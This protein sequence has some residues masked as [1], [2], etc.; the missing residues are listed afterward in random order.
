MRHERTRGQD[1][2]LTPPG[3]IEALGPFDLDPCAPVVRPW[4]TAQAHYTIEDDGLS[5]PWTG[6]VWMNPPYG[7]ATP[8]WIARLAEHGQ[9][10]ALLMVRTD[11][12]WFQDHVFERA[13]GLFFL[14]GR[15]A[16]HEPDGRKADPA[17]APCVLVG[18]GPGD[19]LR[20][21]EAFDDFALRGAYVHL[22][23]PR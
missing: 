4:D 3:V 10:T 18:Y 1:E 23:G 8:T 20:L 5:K 22:R 15:V 6:R 12:A 21:R 14:R 16:F 19:A 2:W 11:T 7:R 13:S 17:P 9:G